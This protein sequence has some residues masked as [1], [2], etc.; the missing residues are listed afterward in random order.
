MAAYKVFIF[1]IVVAISLKG[2]HLM[3]DLNPGRCIYSCFYVHVTWKLTVAFSRAAGWG[4]EVGWGRGLNLSLI[5]LCSGSRKYDDY[6]E[7][8]RSLCYRYCVLFQSI[9]IWIYLDLL[10]TSIPIVCTLIVCN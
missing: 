8:T 3:E 5:I 2:V 4:G 7:N 6:D 1:L 9:V 10:A